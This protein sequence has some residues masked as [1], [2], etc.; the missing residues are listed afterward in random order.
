[1]G[2]SGPRITKC[3]KCVTHGLWPTRLLCPWDFPGKNTGVG[4][5]FLLQGSNPCLLHLLH[6]Q[7]DSLLSEP[8]EKARLNPSL[9]SHWMQ[10][11]RLLASPSPQTQA[12]AQSAPHVL[13][14]PIPEDPLPPRRCKST[15]IIRAL[16][17]QSSLYP[18][19][20]TGKHLLPLLLHSPPP[21][22]LLLFTS[23]LKTF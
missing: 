11:K 20:L 3:E 2:D 6:W 21:L 7:V 23:N 18:L 22:P 10:L 5:R 16:S 19:A 14:C 12:A 8:S 4:C 9:C 1:M 13:T 17:T 15:G